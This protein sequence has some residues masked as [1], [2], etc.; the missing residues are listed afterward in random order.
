ML[1]LVARRTV[2]ALMSVIAAT[3]LIYLRSAYLDPRVRVDR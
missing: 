3:M 2:Q 1:K